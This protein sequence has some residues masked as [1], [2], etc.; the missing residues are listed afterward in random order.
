MRI[1]T[2]KQLIERLKADCVLVVE[3]MELVHLKRPENVEA[4]VTATALIEAK[5]DK[6]VTLERVWLFLTESCSC[7]WYWVC[8]DN[9]DVRAMLDVAATQDTPVSV[10][11]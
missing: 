9:E 3:T 6:S 10:T 4:E 5:A 11:A 2:G 7:C 1:T 8:R